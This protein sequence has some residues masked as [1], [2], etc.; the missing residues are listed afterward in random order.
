M[1]DPVS[2]AK[3]AFYS[4]DGTTGVL[5]PRG[6]NCFGD[7]GSDGAMLFV[8]P[9][10][11]QSATVLGTSFAIAGP[12]IELAIHSGDTSGRFEVA[13]VIAR[14]F[15][16]HMAFAQGVIAEGIEPAGDFVTGAPPTDKLTVKGG[17]VVEF[18]TP[19]NAQGVGSIF[20][21]LTPSADPIDGVAVLEGQTPDAAVL[22]VR[23][24]PD[25]RALTPMIVQ[26]F[27]TDSAPANGTTNAQPAAAPA[28]IAPQ[29]TPQ[30]VASGGG[31]YA[32]LATVGNFYYAL[33]QGDGATASSLVIPQK[34]AGNYAPAALSNYYGRMA[35]PLRLQSSSM[36]G[37]NTVYVR[38]TFVAAGGRPCNG[39]ANVS[40]T[41]IGGQTLIAGVQA[42]NGC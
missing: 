9:I 25:M 37:P 4:A 20:S 10:P 11:M 18:E 31:S 34:R 33:G 41:Q 38:Y 12:G 2:A 1:L 30:P 23:L 15:P 16:A 13:K 29:P 22:S 5:A 39:A 8:A 35:Q 27:E 17:T 42:L 32:P 21:L 36:T 14:L 3:L 28:P 26:Q 6:W 40:T 19:G 7:Y 24:T